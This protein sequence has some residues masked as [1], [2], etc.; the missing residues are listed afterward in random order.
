MREPQPLLIRFGG[1]EI[2]EANAQLKRGAEVLA[3]PPRAFA[4]LCELA[5]RPGQLVTKDA[6]LDA[7][8]GHRHVSESVLKSAVRQLRAVLG[9]D[10]RTPRFIGTASRRG[11]RFIAPAGASPDKT[12]ER[13]SRISGRGEA[14]S[15]LR[16]AWSRTAAGQRQL[17]WLAGEAGVGKTTVVDE[18]VA[19]LGAVA[20]A[21]GQC[22]EQHGQGEPYLPVLEALATLCRADP[23]LAPLLRGFAPTWLLQLPWL[24]TEAEREGLRHELAGT[25]Q[26]RMLREFGELLDRYTQ[27]KRLLLVTEDLHWSDQATVT[28]INHVA[29]RRGKAHWMW[30]ATF[31]AAEVIAEDH[32][33]KAVRHELRLHRLCDEIALDPFSEQ[34]LADYVARR[35]GVATGSDAFVKALHRHTDGLPLFVANVMDELLLQGV[36]PAAFAARDLPNTFE[37]L[38]LPE[39]LAG[40]MERRIARL[41]AGQIALLETASACG[42]EFAPAVVALALARDVDWV[43]QQCVALAD[44]QQWLTPTAA[45]HGMAGDS[46]AR[47]AFRHALVRHVFRNRLG[48]L[49]RAQLH[50]RVA[51]ALADAALSGTV[52]SAAELAAQFEL[53]QDADAALPH[54]AAA[55][56]RALQQFAPGDALRLAERGLGL[57]ASCRPGPSVQESVAT[58]HT[59]RGAAAAQVHGVSAEETLQSFEQAQAALEGWPQHPLRSMALHGLGLGLFLSGAVQQARELAERRLAQALQRN[60]TVLV[61]TACDLL[62]QILKLEGPPHEAITVLEQGI[63]AAELLDEQTLQTAFVLDPLVNMHAALAIPVLLA[64]LDRQAKVHS[65]LALARAKALK[66]PMARMIA[67]WLALLCEL[68]R[69]AKDEVAAL[70]AQLRTITDEGA[71]AQGEGPSAWFLGLVQAWNGM[72]VDG[73]ARIDHAYRSYAQVGM[74]Y[75]TA[76]VLGYATEALILAGDTVQALR[77]VDDALQLA[78]RLHDHS[79]RTQLLLLKRRVFIAERA[80]REAQDVARQALFE[81]RR[82]RSP[83]LEITVLVDLCGSPQAAAADLDALRQA[84]TGLPEV[85]KAPLMNRA[86]AVL[87]LR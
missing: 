19:S 76:E 21:H 35:L 12:T 81:A 23:A 15:R 40:V 16:A 64:G 37:T 69:G 63:R 58:L 66:Q 18:F 87:G 45:V 84:V 38:S 26:A 62:G 28:L 27:D 46:T 73:H 24:C 6:L 75:G 42:L 7:V 50:R 29:R 57:A 59:L 33:M 56:A 52:V 20:F 53:G 78:S 41:S 2:D 83:W 14:L 44:R 60:D 85:S 74:L 17:C 39:S 79:Y 13:A 5:R 43:A 4:V 70:A 31:R 61:V 86:R 34:E 80:E 10:A 65:D 32:P 47:Y 72:P 55:S 51:V 49:A 30:L 25:S 3:L 48:A 77:R 9:D 8:W 67:I 11:Y 36:L 71:L 82:Q 1:F 68:R 22:V 54:C